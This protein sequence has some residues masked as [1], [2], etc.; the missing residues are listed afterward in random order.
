MAAAQ[1]ALGQKTNGKAPNSSSSSSSNLG[2]VVPTEGAAAAAASVPLRLAD[3]AA[4]EPEQ[5]RRLQ[6]PGP[7]GREVS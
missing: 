3:I 5:Q 7:T 2:W 6:L 4:A 1:E